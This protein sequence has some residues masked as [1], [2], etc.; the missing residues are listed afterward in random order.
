MRSLAIYAAAA[1]A[2]LV[3]CYAFWGW[4]RLGKPV[5]WLAAGMVSLALFAWLLTL[6]HVDV[7]GRA[8]AVYGGIYIAVS[9]AWLR[10]VDG[11]PPD[12]FDLIGG[13]ICLLGAGIIL[14]A[15]RGA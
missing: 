4:M 11:V 12:R 6:V 15:P 2:E 13:A 1:L 14:W 9:L 3:G 5:W 8:Y 7:A 10:L